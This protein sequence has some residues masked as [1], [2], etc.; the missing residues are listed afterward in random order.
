MKAELFNL[1]LLGHY[2][3]VPLV[4]PSDIWDIW[5]ICFTICLFILKEKKCQV[6]FSSQDS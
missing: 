3:V 2:L 1:V 4:E 5:V 6:F